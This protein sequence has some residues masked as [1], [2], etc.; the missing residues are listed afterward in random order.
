LKRR[1]EAA[2]GERVITHAEVG[3]GCIA[4]ASRMELSDGRT[5]F[6]K[7]GP[8]AAGFAAEAAG[9]RELA[10]FGGEGR[11]WL[12]P[13]VPEVLHVDEG[14]MVLEW[15]DLE[16]PTNAAAW[17]RALAH[18]H[19]AS[20]GQQPSFG[21][22]IPGMLGSTP[23]DHAWHDDWPTFW[24]TRRLRP[25]LELVH[26]DEVRALGDKLDARLVELLDGCAARPCLIHGDLWS[27]NIAQA[28]GHP[29]TFDPA[30]YWADR[31]VEFGML[32][33]MGRLGPKFEAAYA[34]AW[35]LPA[36]AD[37]RIGVYELHHHLNHL[38]L[39]GD[40]YR[41]GCVRLMRQLLTA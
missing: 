20:A 25:M 39:F 24:R 19:R 12:G 36:G 10:R 7:G 8:G 31:A 11:Q 15:L 9:L 22:D 23:Q 6:A 41:P 27:G 29:V 16:S 32:R 34:E 1:V 28:G 4:V 40:S 13:R 3:G 38:I 30:A 17:G 18:L 33:W 2:S 5:V 21:F 35:P 14:V 26:D 37:R